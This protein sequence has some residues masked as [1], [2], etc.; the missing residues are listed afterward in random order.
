LF[1]FHQSSGRVS[2]FLTVCNRCGAMRILLVAVPPLIGDMATKIFAE[3]CRVLSIV[4][5]DGGDAPTIRAVAAT[6]D[7]VVCGPDIDSHRL[8]TELLAID[9]GVRLLALS[10]DGR[11]AEL[12]RAGQEPSRLADFTPQQLIEALGPCGVADHP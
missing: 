11:T 10:A 2:I 9:R 8:A 6:A 1:A 7:L 12:H 4:R 5:L 3:R